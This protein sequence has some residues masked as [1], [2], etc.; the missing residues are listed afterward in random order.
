MKTDG[1]HDGGLSEEAPETP[2]APLIAA[3]VARR[4]FGDLL[5]R[6]G[7]LGERFTITRNGKPVATLA[8]IE[9]GAVVGAV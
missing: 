3:E 8:P 7:Y 4:Q 5:N 2:E 9:A 6:I 1:V